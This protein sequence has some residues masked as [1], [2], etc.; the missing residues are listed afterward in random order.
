VGAIGSAAIP[1][2]LPDD[3]KDVAELAVRADGQILFAQ[4]LVEA[5]GPVPDLALHAA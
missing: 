5:A 4:A 2:A 3:V 1:V